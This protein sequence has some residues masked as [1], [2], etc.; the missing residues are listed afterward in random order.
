MTITLQ[1]NLP[2]RYEYF[3][4]FETT[5]WNKVYQASPEELETTNYLNLFSLKATLPSSFL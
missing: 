1:Q 5:G 4:L 2:D 3:S